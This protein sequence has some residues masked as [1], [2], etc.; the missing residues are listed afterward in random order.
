MNL[1]F[2]HNLYQNVIIYFLKLCIC[3]PPSNLYLQLI[4]N[5][6]RLQF[7]CNFPV[8]YDGLQVSQSSF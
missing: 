3:L 2:H 8:S 6:L 5:K 4:Q 7:L 1:N